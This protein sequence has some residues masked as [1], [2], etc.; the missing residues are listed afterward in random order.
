MP[1]I[2]PEKIL[3]FREECAR[4]FDPETGELKHA[5]KLSACP[6]CDS[7]KLKHE[8][9]LQGF[10]YLRCTGC[11][12]MFVNPRL[13]DIGSAE[14]YNSPFYNALVESEYHRV[15]NDDELYYSSSVESSELMEMIVGTVGR[16][17]EKDARILDVGCGGGALLRLLRDRLGLTNLLGIDLNGKAARF[18]REVRGVNVIHGDAKHD[19]QGQKFDLVLSI[20]SIEHMNDFD[21]YMQMLLASLVPGGQVLIT[22]PRNSRLACFLFGHAAD[23]YMAPNHINFFNDKNLKRYLERFGLRVTELQMLSSARSPGLL[24]RRFLAD[25]EYVA[26]RPPVSGPS[27][28]ILPRNLRGDVRRYIRDRYAYVANGAPSGEV[29]SPSQSGGPSLLRRL[30]S[31]FSIPIKTNMLIV[32]RKD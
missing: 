7:K 14:F 13:N 17:V 16:I 2:D 4:H 25:S 18:A 5:L 32:A 1:E 6:V 21:D 24:Y 19:L 10:R 30:V 31:L 20:E 28:V 23:G 9:T 8:F 12:F 29:S 11:R 3:L 27:W 22:T 26:Y 15:Q